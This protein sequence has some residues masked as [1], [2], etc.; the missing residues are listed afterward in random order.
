MNSQI[1]KP[2]FRQPVFLILSIATLVM[3]I[4]SGLSVS[5]ASKT[6]DVQITV[7]AAGR[8]NPWIDLQD[9]WDLP[10]TYKGQAA[11]LM[12]PGEVRPLTLASADFD[13]DGVADL[14]SGYARS[15]RGIVTLQLGNRDAIAAK[16]DQ[17]VNLA[18]TNKSPAPLL[19]TA[20]TVRV[21]EPADFLAAGDFNYDGHQDVITAARGSQTLYLLAGDGSGVIS[22]AEAISLPGAVTAMA[23]GEINQK[24]ELAD[25]V[26]GILGSQGS[27]VL[28]YEGST[29]GLLGRPIVYALPAEVIAL[30]MG[31]LDDESPVDLA[32]AAGTEVIIIHG[33]NRLS[34]PSKTN[35]VPL[36]DTSADRRTFPFLIRSIALGDFNSDEERRTDLALLADDGAVHLLTHKNAGDKLEAWQNGTLSVGPWIGATQLVRAKL[37]SLPSDDLLVVD[38]GSAQVHILGGALSTSGSLLTLLA[39]LDVESAPA[40]LAQ[41]RLSAGDKQGIVMLRKN[42]LW[43]TVVVPAEANEG[44]VPL[45]PGTCNACSGGSVSCTG[46]IDGTDP[47]AT[48]RTEVDG[49]PTVCP[50]APVCGAAAAGTFSYDKYSFTNNS[51][52]TQCYTVTLNN[53]LGCGISL[54]S[55]AY[56]PSF[57]PS[58]ACA[59][60]LGKN[61]D[62]VSVGL[63]LSYSFNVTNGQCFEVVV[64]NRSTNQVCTGGSYGLSVSPCPSITAGSCPPLSSATKVVFVQ[65]PTNAVAD[66]NISPPVT[67]QLQDASNSNVLT[68]GVPIIVSLTSGTGTL[69]GTTTQNTNASGLATFNDLHIGVVGNGKQL[70]ASSGSLTADLS[71]LFNITQPAPTPCNACSSGS[72]VCSGQLIGHGT[73]TTTRAQ[74]D[75]TVS[76]CAGEACPG[77]TSGA[78]NYL[79][80]TYRNSTAAPVCYTVS[81]SSTC[82]GSSDFF[83]AAYSPSF[84]P[85]NV[86]TNF[87]GDLGNGSSTTTSYQFTVPS[88]VNFEIVVWNR[89][90][91]TF[92]SS[93]FQLTLT[94]CA[95]VPPTTNATKVVIVQQPTDTVVDQNITPAVTVQLQN[96]SNNNVAEANVPINIALTSGTGTLLG[97]LTQMTN[98]SGLATFNNLHIN[99][100]GTNKQLTAASSGLIPSISNFFNITAAAATPCN[101]C[102]SGSIVCSGQLIGH[103]T[104]TTTRKATDGTVSG[105]GG[106]VCSGSASG[107]F[108]YLTY[109][110]K[111]STAAPVCYTVSFNSTC[112]GTSDFFSAAYSP[113]FVPANVCTNFLGDLGNG[114]STTNSYQFT[115]PSGQNFDIVVWNRIGN[116]FCASPFT[117]TLTP[118]ACQPITGTVSGG[119]NICTGGS[120]T[121]TVN[122]SGGV[123]P[124]TV[125]LTNGGGTQTGNGPTF[126]FSVSPSMTTTY[127]VDTAMS[128]DANN[129]PITNSG[130]ATVTII[131]CADVTVSKSGPATAG[132][133]DTITYT[134]TAS[135]PGAAA[136]AN[137]VVTDN[138]AAC[139]SFVSCDST[140]SGVCGGSGNNR[141]VT[142]SSLASGASATITIMATVNANCAPSVDNTASITT[143]SAET[144]S[145]NNT[146]NTVT[147]TVTCADVSVTKSAGA[148]PVCST[149]NITYTINYNNA[150]PS[151]AANALVSDVMPVGTSLVSVTTPATWT[152]SDLVPSGGNGTITFTKA[153]SPNADAAVF[154]IVVSI[155]GSVADSAVIQNTATVSSNTS[156]PNNAN[157]TS[158][159]TSTTVKKPPTSATAGGPQTICVLGTTASLGGN[160]P[161]LG[162]G[163]WSVQS[164][165]TGTFSPNASDP[166]AT[167][168]HLT[169][170]GPI[171]VRWTISNPPCADSFAE[172]TIT[173][174]PTPATPTIT[175][176]GPTTFCAGGSVTLTSS[177]ASGNQWFLNG[178]P[179]GGETNQSYVATASGNYT[180][181]VTTSGCPSAMSAVTT[182]TVNP[183]PAT[184]TITPGGPTTFCTGGSVTLTSSSASG[185][186]WFLNGNPIGGATNQTF[187][188]TA[189]G[190]YTVQVTTSGC[191]SAPS[192]ATIVTVNPIPATPTITPGG[193]TSFC[194]GGSVTLTSSSASGNQWFLDGNPIGGA[195]NPTFIATASG[196]YTV[197][198][199]ALGCTSAPSAATTVTV[200]PSPSAATVGGPQTICALSTTAGLGGNTPSSGT[201]TWTVQSGGTGTFTPNANTG[202]A[203]FTHTGGAGPIVLRWTISNPPC[204]DSFAE[205]TITITQSPT[206]ATVGGP[207]TICALGTTAGLGGSTPTSGTGTWTVQSGG[208]GTFSPNANT[209]NATFTHTSGTGPIVLRWTIANPPCTSSFAEVTITITQSPTTATVGG[210]QTICDGSSTTGLGGNTPSSGTGTWTVQSAGAG[211]FTPNANTPNATF[212]STTGPG[213]Y[214]LRWTISNPPCPDSF[215]EVTITVKQQPTATTGGPQT[216]CAGGTSASLGGNTPSGGATGTWTIVTAGA[217]G[218]FNPNANTPGATF[219]HTGGTGPITLRWTVSNPPCTDATADVVLTITQP[220]TM[221]TV[222]PNQTIAP[223]GT[224]AP[225][226]GNTPSV[227]TGMWSIVTAGVTGTF[228]PNATTPNATWTHATGS[229]MVVLRWTISNPPCPSS[230]ADVIIQIGVAP[231]ITCPASPVMAD[232]TSGECQAPVSFTVM[233][234][235]IPAPTV[236]CS[237]ASGSIFPVGNTTV[238]CTASNG[239]LPN[240]MC[241]FTVQVNDTQAPVFTNGCPAGIN[242]AAQATCPFSTSGMTT[243]ATP[244]ASDNC[245]GVTVACVPPSGSMFPVGTTTV[246]CTATDASGNTAMCSF[247]VAV[248]NLCLQDNSNPGNVV[249]VNTSTGAYR[250]CC[251]GVLVAS[252]IG[253][254]NIRGCTVSISGSSNNKIV[255]I[256]VDGAS[257]RGTAAI[258]QG[259]GI[260]CIISDSNLANNTCV[261]N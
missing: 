175:P 180:V 167:F 177:S 104:P 36:R 142:F 121:V 55:A 118:C 52:A 8:G 224:T 151:A 172:V 78:F 215:A 213:N 63:T 158:A 41:M 195:T 169:G 106:E 185:N 107:T 105:C 112:A 81:F 166:N 162:T 73:P 6:G 120:S 170:A 205:V 243:Y 191:S 62:P 111:N 176:G 194:A 246:T 57:N 147:T 129:C 212:M 252:G 44:L 221:A 125:V 134:L 31:Q 201:G 193:P 247:S 82:T 101:A 80:Y 189:S 155:N 131:S 38:P 192:A 133:G 35:P 144:N 119:G 115:V 76:G 117:L 154:T 30:A 94:P 87:L 25:V 32:V 27:Q 219:T 2:L 24:D 163:A 124:H 223:G 56:S 135:N 5:S 143:T 217:T 132:C 230:T 152:R 71:A 198:V 9:G 186:Q 68:A 4:V 231:T 79:T 77:S 235:G 48:Q 244:T 248:F 84:S 99:V 225:L 12:K 145:G 46:T 17:S 242:M 218:T 222:G 123:A 29:G 236:V 160:T 54:H 183:I 146:S 96:N 15:K 74:V 39:S 88:G 239:V 251:N 159:P 200:T 103:G 102:S 229:G 126:N 227:G 108:N 89:I 190:S 50:T 156:D 203:T 49:I 174:T 240:A 34:S 187:S 249:L 255:Q 37:S 83:S 196:N 75:G 216:I 58:N 26:I 47:I 69:L 250:F 66:V 171:V 114:S 65:E 18:S 43:P 226:G 130:S 109:T 153:S 259:G 138:L 161:T 261:C 241:S 110:Y 137:V 3:L 157:N 234:T 127:M 178:N 116:T 59:S 86:C 92:C 214:T 16:T 207:Q 197:T 149:S 21:P 91:N 245:P 188:A 233:S 210:P 256:T 95:E 238:T 128:H 211:T 93:P 10:T 72:I 258:K 90:G 209:P 22:S 33:Q 257:M 165:G 19:S 51:G 40:A 150:G 28:V 100:V 98:A 202:N 182:V 237:P 20:W 206:T 204:P 61:G 164:G 199:T 122:V 254:L 14:V 67:V 113:S 260:L 53:T 184:P 181:Q 173:I 7:R 228:N 64:Y 232:A 85:A 13:E 139:L 23:A 11:R 140:L 45:G 136:A 42:Q 179:I 253:T 60:L 208:A 70:T 97:T 148:S 1:L 141:T 168:H 220:P